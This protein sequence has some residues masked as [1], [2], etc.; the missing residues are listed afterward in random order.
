MCDTKRVCMPIQIHIFTGGI[1]VSSNTG[2]PHNWCYRIYHTVQR[3][4]VEVSL[5]DTGDRLRRRNINQPAKTL[6]F[7]RGDTNSAS[8]D[9]R[10]QSEQPNESHLPCDLAL[11]ERQEVLGVLLQWRT[12]VL[13]SRPFALRVSMWTTSDS[14]SSPITALERAGGGEDGE[15][16]KEVVGRKRR[17]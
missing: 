13:H 10:D 5:C 16:Q 17:K 15:E 14:L 11:N 1:V 4:G 12:A 8:L 2:K 9:C 3:R 7:C 6:R